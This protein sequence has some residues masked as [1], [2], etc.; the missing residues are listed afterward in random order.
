MNYQSAADNS[1]GNREHGE[2]TAN[3]LSA[4]NQSDA[5]FT[6]TSIVFLITIPSLI[7]QAGIVIGKPSIRPSILKLFKQRTTNN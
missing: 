4:G 2:R 1:E 3:R 6:S 7:N 5:E